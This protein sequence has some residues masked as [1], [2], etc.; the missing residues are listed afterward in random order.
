MKNLLPLNMKKILISFLLSIVS[1]H[2]NHLISQELNLEGYGTLDEYIGQIDHEHYFVGKGKGDFYNARVFSVTNNQISNDKTFIGHF[3]GN[4]NSTQKERN[5]LSKQYLKWFI[6]DSN[7]YSIYKHR[8]VGFAQLNIYKYD[9]NLQVID[10]FPLL[11]DRTQNNDDFEPVIHISNKRIG[12][13]SP[14]DRQSSTFVFAS[15]DLELGENFTSYF[16]LNETAKYSCTD[17]V[18]NSKNNFFLLLEGPENFVKE[19]LTQKIKPESVNCK[20]VRF[21]DE[22]VNIS[23]ISSSNGNEFYRSFKFYKS[24]NDSVLLCG[25]VFESNEGLYFNGYRISSLNFTTGLESNEQLVHLQKVKNNDLLTKNDIKS[26]AIKNHYKAPYQHLKEIIPLKNGSYLFISEGHNLLNTSSLSITNTNTNNF[27]T[28]SFFETKR[29][30]FYCSNDDIF[31]SCFD[32]S[33]GIVWTTKTILRNEDLTMKYGT[34]GKGKTYFSDFMEDGNQ[35]NLYFPHYPGLL[36]SP[37][38]YRITYQHPTVAKFSIDLTNGTATLK[39]I[40]KTV[41]QNGAECIVVGASCPKNNENLFIWIQSRNALAN[42]NYRLYTLK[43]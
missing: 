5:D 7:V 1:I 23:K 12:I 20:L 31:V 6:I 37:P 29:N 35:L 33:A 32:H 18:V 34:A 42:Y 15:Y 36:T 24:S 26:S 9:R 14:L 30:F 40:D 27:P 25:L 38:D 22:E 17:F 4:K 21:I 3:P 11:I 2:C 19:T 16:Q 41:S 28:L 43:R 39:E 13:V 10:S 8:N